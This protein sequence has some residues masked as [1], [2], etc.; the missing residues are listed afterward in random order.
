MEKAFL[1]A[2]ILFFAG[3]RTTVD[4]VYKVDFVYINETQHCILIEG[5]WTYNNSEEKELRMSLDL[6][7]NGSSI[8]QKKLE[9]NDFLQNCV[10]EIIVTY[11]D[12]ITIQH[13]CLDVSVR[14]LFD[15]TQYKLIEEG[16]HKLRYE[17]T[18]TEEDYQ[19]ALAIYLKE[20]P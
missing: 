20:N 10:H 19:V 15:E 8:F 16:K 13:D 2:C 17:Y 14:C 1:I 5:Y 12:S 11:D 18:F 7:P 9:N 3:C 6:P 4:N